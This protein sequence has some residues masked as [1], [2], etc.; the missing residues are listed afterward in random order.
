MNRK[1]EWT[2]EANFNTN[3][4][5]NLYG[6]KFVYG[7]HFPNGELAVGY[8]YGRDGMWKD[9]QPLEYN[10]NRYPE[11]GTANHPAN[12]KALEEEANGTRF[13]TCRDAN[14]H[15]L[16]DF[17][18]DGEIDT[19]NGG[20]AFH[21]HSGRGIANAVMQVPYTVFFF[22]DNWLARILSIAYGR[23]HPNGLSDYSEFTRWRIINGDSAY[24]QPYRDANWPD[25]WALNG[26]WYLVNGNRAGALAN[27]ITIFT[28]SKCEYDRPNQRFTYPGIGE[29]YYL[30][31]WKILTD[32]LL[33]EGWEDEISNMLLQHSI[34]L[35]SNILSTQETN[36]RD[37]FGWRTE[38]NRQEALINIE[39]TTCNVLGLAPCSNAV[40]E[41]GRSPLTSDDCGYF[42]RP[43]Q[44]LSAVIDIS[45]AGF[46]TRG[47]GWLF[48]KRESIY[49]ADF[50][51]RAPSPI[52]QMVTIDIF[53]NFSGSILAKRDVQA[54]D[55]GSNND[56]KC[57]TLPF[58]INSELNSIELR[59]YWNGTANLDI[60]AIR[61]R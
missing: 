35:R 33:E 58:W 12:P 11:Y 47:P 19:H 54:E 13:M 4:L 42:L 6:G 31:L 57:I 8:V 3:R 25:Q 53:D 60:A 10:C 30:G 61:V 48:P 36:G 29:S 22:D 38:S 41:A 23:Q 44:V 55:L 9:M 28:R 7:R 14:G 32:N 50:Y 24:W 20:F 49:Q 2:A 37:L 18:H 16:M 39:T 17:N 1:T 26:L 56:W 59:T 15:L 43:H 34:A 45:R 51:L 46:L 27:W 21:E 5:T 40:F 52:G